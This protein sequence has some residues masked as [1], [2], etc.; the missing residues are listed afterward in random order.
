M[1]YPYQI[2][3]EEGYHKAYKKSVDD[4]EGFWADIAENFIWKSKWE[5]V[6]SWNF[7]EPRIKWFAG[8]KL[9]ITENCLDRWLEVQPDAPAIIWEP[10]DPN[11]NTGCLLIRDCILR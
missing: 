11:E 6:L 10:N 5:N 7:K 3:S 2:T 1:S 9:N 8:G 4:P